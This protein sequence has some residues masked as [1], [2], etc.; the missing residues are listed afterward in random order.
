MFAVV[1]VILLLKSSFQSEVA[2]RAILTDE[3]L[4]KT[5]LSTEEM[6]NIFAVSGSSLINGEAR[7]FQWQ[8]F[9]KNCKI[10]Q[11]SRKTWRGGL[12]HLIR[13]VDINYFLIFHSKKDSTLKEYTYE[14]DRVQAMENFAGRLT[15]IETH[16]AMYKEGTES[17]KQG[18][19]EYS[20][21]GVEEMNE[22]VNGFVVLFFV[23]KSLTE[24]QLNSVVVPP[25]LN[26]T[27]LGYV[28]S[29]RNQVD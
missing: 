15:T 18:I 27:A 3:S 5:E 17:Y 20:D 8:K 9:R 21:L 26:Y 1:L 12:P 25:S 14:E 22:R 4:T 16:N 24:Q 10:Y 11:K 29:V 19:N 28:T 7:T 13:V 2:H 23:G 6:F